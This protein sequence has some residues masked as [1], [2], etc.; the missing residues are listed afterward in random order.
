MVDDNTDVRI[1]DMVDDMA[2]VESKH[3]TDVEVLGLM[4]HSEPA[5]WVPVDIVD[6][7]PDSVE[8]SEEYVD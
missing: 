6:C 5:E 2:A 8:S 4:G 3:K 7:S 1:A